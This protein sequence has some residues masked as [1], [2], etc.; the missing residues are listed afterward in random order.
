MGKL[1]AAPVLRPVLTYIYF[2]W[3]RTAKM[4][5]NFVRLRKEPA[6][7]IVW[8]EELQEIHAQV[9]G[10]LRLLSSGFWAVWCFLA[11]GTGNIN[12]RRFA[13]RLRVSGIM[14]RYGTMRKFTCGWSRLPWGAVCRLRQTA[15]KISWTKTGSG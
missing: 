1:T 8:N 12:T 7:H 4:L 3:R 2:G 13:S 11:F 6:L 14:S 10:E 9:M 5:K 15:V